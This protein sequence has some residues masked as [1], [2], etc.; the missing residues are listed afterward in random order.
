[1]A[2]AAPMTLAAAP[3][4]WSALE[5]RRTTATAKNPRR[6]EAIALAGSAAPDPASGDGSGASLSLVASVI[7]SRG[8]NGHRTAAAIAALD[9]AKRKLTPNGK[10]LTMNRIR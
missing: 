1:M 4:G 5:K 3:R 8:S 7:G 6:I 2:R 9:E 10:S